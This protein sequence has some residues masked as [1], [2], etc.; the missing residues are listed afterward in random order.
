MLL[1]TILLFF[2]LPCLVIEY[3]VSFSISMANRMELSKLV[4]KRT[5]EEADRRSV[6]GKVERLKG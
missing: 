1:S 3:G 4:D 2:V 5:R 6:T